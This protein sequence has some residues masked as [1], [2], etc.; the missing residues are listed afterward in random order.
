MEAD[1]EFTSWQIRWHGALRRRQAVLDELI[2]TGALSARELSERLEV[3]YIGLMTEDKTSSFFSFRAE[4]VCPYV[5]AF[6]SRFLWLCAG[7][8]RF[9]LSIKPSFW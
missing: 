5:L 3:W 4:S 1:P 9:P 7:C 8:C 6:Q 2:H